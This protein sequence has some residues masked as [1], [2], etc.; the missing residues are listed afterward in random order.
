[1][2]YLNEARLEYGP[3]KYLQTRT[4]TLAIPII[5]LTALDVFEIWLKLFFIP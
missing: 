3:L 1:M 4:V 5:E 2:E